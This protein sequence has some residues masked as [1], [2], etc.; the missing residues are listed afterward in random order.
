M[1][2][3]KAVYITLCITLAA[4]FLISN[5]RM[6]LI[7][8]LFLA[9]LPVILKLLLC[10]GAGKVKL[11]MQ[12]QSACVRGQAVMLRLEAEYPVFVPVGPVSI[13]AVFQNKMFG[14]TWEGRIFLEPGRGR[15]LQFEFPFCGKNCGK[16]SLKLTETVCY[17]FLRL[18]GKKLPFQAEKTFMICLLYTS[19]WDTI[20]LP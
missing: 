11:R 12:I 6:L 5:E 16:V 19:I 15:T 8:L 3:N 4:V 20:P 14:D 18:T 7:L 2:G 13:K 1:R 10:A 9:L 17:D